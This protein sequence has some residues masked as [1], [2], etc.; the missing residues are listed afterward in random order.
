[1]SD[2][3]AAAFA[4][5]AHKYAEPGGFDRGRE[6]ARLRGCAPHNAGTDQLGY[7]VAA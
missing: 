2:T 1:M 6:A 5:P 7:S 4:M 3:G